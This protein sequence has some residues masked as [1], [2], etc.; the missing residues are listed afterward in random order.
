MRALMEA[1]GFRVRVWDDVTAETAGPATADAIPS[2][3][4]FAPRI[5]MARCA[6]RDRARP[7][8]FAGRRTVDSGG[9][10]QS[11][12]VLHRE[13]RAAGGAGAGGAPPPSRALSAP[14]PPPSFMARPGP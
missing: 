5:I 4:T 2:R 3:P 8:S 10:S 6:R 1:A 13:P 11:G 7:S 12:D 9:S 14:P